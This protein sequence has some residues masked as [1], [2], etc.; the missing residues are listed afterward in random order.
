MRS[1][2][3]GQTVTN[4][5]IKLLVQDHGGTWRDITTRAF[6]LSLDCKIDSKDWALSV[7]FNNHPSLPSLDPLDL[8][9]LHVINGA[10]LLGRYHAVRLEIS[11]D[12]GISWEIMF[13]GFAGPDSVET[14]DIV[15]QYDAIRA[16]FSD[17][18]S[19]LKEILMIEKLQ[20]KDITLPLL[21]NRVLADNGFTETVIVRNDPGKIFTQ[22]EVGEAAVWE[23]LQ[24]LVQ[25][26]GFIL[27]YTWHINS[28]QLVLYDPLRTK[29][30]PDGVIDRDF[31]ER[32]IRTS[33]ATV[34]T[35]IKVP[36]RSLS[37]APKEIVV[38]DDAARLKYGLPINGVRLH[39]KMILPIDN[40]IDTTGEAEIFGNLVLHDVKEPS[41]SVSVDLTYFWPEPE[42]HDL[43]QLVA[44]DYTILFG[45]MNITHKIDVENQIGTTSLTGSIDRV[46][47]NIWR[48]DLRL[49]KIER[50]VNY[51]LGDGLEPTKVTGLSLSTMW[52]QA[53]DGA[54]TPAVMARW[55]RNAEW[56]LSHYEIWV[57]RENEMTFSH[58]GD[59][60]EPFYV[61]KPLG[62]GEKISVKVRAVDWR[63]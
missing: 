15:T 8:T 38:A 55:D 5:L 12:G 48:E 27:A 32:R 50:N 30:I 44:P 56:D 16:H 41:P 19:V 51:L 60:S 37:G 7:T 43:L 23:I 10:P 63:R 29:T 62:A 24:N 4:T 20:Y 36:F 46:I 54:L 59:S 39:R 40:L 25:P 42:I 2:T 28:F 47:G 21:L 17:K 49:K 57:R 58:H 33:E 9:G 53:D 13:E 3:N 14:T 52:D 11:K 34:R 18:S 45:V 1:I 35:W 22:V 26:T 6:D 61:I 31:T